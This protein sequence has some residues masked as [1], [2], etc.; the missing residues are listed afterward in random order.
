MG[1]VFGFAVVDGI[2]WEVP[3]SRRKSGRLSSNGGQVTD[4]DA[5]RALAQPEAPARLAASRERFEPRDRILLSDHLVEVDIGAFGVERGSRQRVRFNVAVELTP[6]SAP[7]DDDVDKIL[8]YDAI[9]DAISAELASERLNLLETLAERIARRLLQ[10]P[11]ALRIH[12]R[13][14][15]LDRASGALGVEIV[16]SRSGEATANTDA[17]RPVDAPRPV[18]SLLSSAAAVAPG[19]PA[20]LE[21]MQA[22]GS[23]LVLCVEAGDLPTPSADD[24]AAQLRIALLAM[25]QNAWALAGNVRGVGVVGTRTE[26]D[27]AMRRGQISVWAPSKIVLDAVDSPPAEPQNSRVLAAW[28]A[29]RLGA[30]ELLGVDCA[31]PPCAVSTRLVPLSELSSRPIERAEPS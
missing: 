29:E 3:S 22:S 31:I 5:G 17:R 26:L 25:E 16:R 30:A 6:R 11:A 9:A 13:I 4:P 10:E 27:W 8:S 19:L 20:W 18:V 21:R 12:L 24:Q 15:K 14:E 23:P 7:L 28:L 2:V 1:H